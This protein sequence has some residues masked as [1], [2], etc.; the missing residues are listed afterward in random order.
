M[1]KLG[2]FPCKFID[3]ALPIIKMS[4]RRTF[5]RITC[6]DFLQL[7]FTDDRIV[8]VR[9]GLNDL[10]LRPG[11]AKIHKC[12]ELVHRLS[13]FWAYTVGSKLDD[14][15]DSL[16]NKFVKFKRKSPL[17]ILGFDT[18]EIFEGQHLFATKLIQ[19]IPNVVV[20]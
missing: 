20:S 3:S 13:F 4:T 18:T 14:L 5:H 15:D 11:K 10:L 6:S 17:G 16:Y 12:N 19:N 7:F 8:W 1:Q 2:L 9:Y